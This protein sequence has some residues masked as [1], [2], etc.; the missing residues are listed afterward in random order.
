MSVRLLACLAIVAGLLVTGVASA[1]E[2][3]QGEFSVQRFSP[4]VGPRNFITV[5]GARTDGKMAFSVGLVGN[6]ADR[7][8][9]LRSCVS[10]TDCDA[11]DASKLR[12][13][14][15]VETLITG[16]L[17]ASLTVVPRLQLGLHV[18]VSFSH[19]AGYHPRHRRRPGSRTSI[20][21]RD[22]VT[23]GG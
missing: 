18:P 7:P 22:S 23:D 4:A 3:Q 2:L 16:E 9:I 17:M 11:N 19:G 21:A 12:E 20:K 10:E 6:Y 8:F 5:Q 14:N 15:V 1:Q 13:I